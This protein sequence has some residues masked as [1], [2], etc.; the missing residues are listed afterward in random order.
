MKKYFIKYILEFFVIVTGISISFWINEW[1]NNRLNRDNA[2]KIIEQVGDET[3]VLEIKKFCK[4]VNISSEEFLPLFLVPAIGLIV[5]SSPSNLIKISGLEPTIE[6]FLKFIKNK[7]GE[8]FR[9]LRALYIDI[10]D[11]L[12]FFLNK[13]DKTT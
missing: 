10:G 9:Y 11:T 1:D 4:Y 3:P 12:I 8:G 13:R 7:Y 2:I 5:T 6:K